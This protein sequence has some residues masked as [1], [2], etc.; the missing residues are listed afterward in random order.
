MNSVI[1]F[2]A[3]DD[4]AQLLH[5]YQ[6]VAQQGD[7]IIRYPFE[8]D[9]NYIQTFALKSWSSGLALVAEIDG[10]IIGEIHAFMSDIFASRHMLI[11]L[12]IVVH[13]KAQG[14]GIGRHL[15]QQFLTLVETGRPDIFRIELYVRS[16]HTK[17]IGL[18]ESLGFK[19][20]GILHDRI[21]TK[22]HTLQTPWMMA[23]KNPNFRLNAVSIASKQHRVSL[24]PV[25]EQD[26]ERLSKLARKIYK[27]YFIH[28]WKDDGQWY[29]N[30]AFST[31]K[32]ASE[33]QE[34]GAR[35]YLS[36]Y[37][38]KA[39]G[40]LKTIDQLGP[41]GKDQDTLKLER[42][43]L[44]PEAKGEGIGQAMLRYVNQ[45]AKQLGR[46]SVWLTVMDSNDTSIA[47]YQKHQF[48]IFGR[49][50]LDFEQVK[51]QYRGMYQMRRLL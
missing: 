16:H 36:Y 28:L 33:L 26:L 1:R 37:Q 29:R 23:W 10:R 2:L 14:Q 39:V 27:A 31:Q 17:A 19:K 47:F 46:K 4:L 6:E 42:I 11:G 21:L 5:L 45:A 13:P 25:T 15:F 32:L 40:F 50:Q 9:A 34:P 22:E 49:H 30:W 20:E 41:E 12:T 48:E 8:I 35:W 3:P 7:G 24:C 43:Y 51:E 44:L 18:Y 38:G